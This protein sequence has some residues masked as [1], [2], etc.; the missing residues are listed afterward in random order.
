M[1]SARSHPSVYR[2]ERPSTLLW[3]Y[4][5]SMTWAYR[6]KPPSHLK[7]IHSPRSSSPP[8]SQSLIL[9][10]LLHRTI[11]SGSSESRY[12]R[13]DGDH[14]ILSPYPYPYPHTLF[15]V[16]SGSNLEVPSER[17]PAGIYVSINIDSQRHWKSTIGVLSSEESVV[18]G[19]T[20]TL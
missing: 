4:T 3:K 19:D 14:S 6:P 18:W 8:H 15:T 13:L 7:V 10:I 5:C 2:A 11:M 9:V 20:V 1:L 12:I 16:I 17:I